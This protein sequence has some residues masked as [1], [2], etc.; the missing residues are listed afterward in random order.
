MFNFDSNEDEQTTPK[1]SWELTSPE[2]AIDGAHKKQRVQKN[3]SGLTDELGK[4]LDEIIA[5]FTD[6]KSNNKTGHDRLT[7]CN[8]KAASRNQCDDGRSP[9]KGPDRQRNLADNTIAFCLRARSH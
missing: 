7:A 8:E 6:T 5:K 3:A 4:I 1:R 9:Q 2:E